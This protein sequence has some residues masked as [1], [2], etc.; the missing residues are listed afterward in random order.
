MARRSKW[1]R[2]KAERKS[3]AKRRIVLLL[4]EAEKA[5]LD[6][7][8]DRANRY[9]SLALR[10]SRRY[11]VQMPPKEKMRVCRECGSYMGG[12]GARTRLNNDVLTVT[13][14]NCNFVKRYPVVKKNERKSK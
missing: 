13:C 3:I 10:I 12:T 2:R 11:K 8:K 9:A 14:S 5:H 7:R 6:G 1:K 4:D